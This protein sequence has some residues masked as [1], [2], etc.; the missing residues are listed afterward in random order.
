MP[1][2]DARGAAAQGPTQGWTLHI[3]AQ[4]HFGDAHPKEIAHHRTASILDTYGKI[5][6]L[7]DPMTTNGQPTGQPSVTVLH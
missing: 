3:D 4:K 5:W 6:L 1:A 7:Y 2:A